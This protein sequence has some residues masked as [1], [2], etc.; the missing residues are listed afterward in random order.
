ML[1]VLTNSSFNCQTSYAIETLDKKSIQSLA[2][3]FDKLPTDPYIERG[4]RA[5]RFS[6]FKVFGDQSNG[7][8][9]RLSH[10]CFF[11][12]KTYNR[13]LGD[14]TRE[15]EELDEFLVQLPAFQR[16]VLTFYEFCQLCAL[17]NTVGV[18]QIRIST[19]NH[20]QGNPAPEG[21][22]QDGVDMVGILCVNR[23]HIAGGETQLYSKQHSGVAFSKVLN[24][25]ELLVFNDRQFSHFTTS[26][27]PTASEAGTRDV[28][29][30]TCP[31][32][33][34]GSNREEI[35]E[36]KTADRERTTPC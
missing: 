21:I 22:H 20:Q 9:E 29:V 4:D 28:F 35:V 34:F 36:K 15:Y 30:F 7:K 10:R 2:V 14:V 33:P 8:L 12:S 1:S 16:A 3:K 17:P 11:Q 18:H 19:S 13:L 23:T 24:P 5:R 26:I 31:D 32:M 6:R 27:E 25:G